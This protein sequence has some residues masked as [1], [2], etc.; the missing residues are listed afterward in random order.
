MFGPENA[1][2]LAIGTEDR[3]KAPNLRTVPNVVMR[4]VRDLDLIVAQVP[5]QATVSVAV[6]LMRQSGQRCLAVVEEGRCVSILTWDRAV[7][8][9]PDVGCKEA[10]E[11][12]K[13]EIDEM[14][15]VRRAASAFVDH[16]LNLAPVVGEDGRFL[17]LLS[18]TQLLRELGRSWDPMTGLSWSDRLR[19]W[20]VRQLEL[21][22]ETTLLFIDLDNF[23]EYNKRHGHVV[24][25]RVLKAAATVLGQAL[26]DDSD[27]LVRYGGDE[28]VVCS[29]R[30]REEVHELAERFRREQFQIDG[31]DEPVTMSVGTSGGKRTRER[32]RVHY[33][34]TIDNLINLA[35]QACL[36]EKRAKR[37]GLE[38]REIHMVPEAGAQVV[39]VSTDG[40]DTSGTVAVAVSVDG[41]TGTGVV[42]QEDLSVLESLVEATAQAFHKACPSVEVRS[43]DSVVFRR[44]DGA[45]CV[46]VKGQ[47]S[48]AGVGRDVRSV[49]PVGPSL[50]DSVAE[51]TLAA[52]A[53]GRDPADG[54]MRGTGGAYGA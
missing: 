10:G 3:P 2:N 19:E 4:A 7:L 30:P 43:L 16:D 12:V 11:P 6:Q 48:V 29:T 54:P 1:P 15:P 23:G 41:A 31:V 39:F 21:G 37:I 27:I 38:D 8:N 40:N 34:A 26:A 17:G 52:L 44:D 24:G 13:V 49:R 5:G 53:G 50:P 47:V 25:D 28:F 20:G 36:A 45:L 18:S 51:A 32:E 46:A 35:S 33:A 22:R 42:D 9:A 14:T